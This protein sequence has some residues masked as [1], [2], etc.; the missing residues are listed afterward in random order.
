MR[1]LFL[2]FFFCFFQAPLSFS[3]SLSPEAKAI[4]ERLPQ[5]QKAVVMN[6]MNLLTG[7]SKQNGKTFD[8]TKPDKIGKVESGT[9]KKDLNSRKK[10]DETKSVVEKNFQ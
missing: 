9:D 8:L 2:L 6:E 1:K 7:N 5:N 4:L 10:V 3:Q